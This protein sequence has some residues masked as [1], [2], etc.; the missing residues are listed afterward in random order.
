MIDEKSG[1]PDGAQ[2]ISDIRYEFTLIGPKANNSVERLTISLE[3]WRRPMARVRGRDLGQPRN[4]P[5]PP[6]FPYAKRPFQV[7]CV[8][9]RRRVL[10]ERDKRVD[11]FGED[12]LHVVLIGPMLATSVGVANAQHWPSG[13]RHSAA[14][15]HGRQHARWLHQRTGPSK[16]TGCW[17]SICLTKP[18]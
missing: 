6:D 14:C 16:V 15:P 11:R 13:F 2:S 5:G 10:E 18:T 17:P 4:G 3:P 9:A 8:G 12:G 1:T 7:V